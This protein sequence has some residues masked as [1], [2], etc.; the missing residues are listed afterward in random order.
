M[1]EG[2]S[3]FGAQLRALRR[4]AGLSQEELAERSGLNVRTIRNLE[5]GLGR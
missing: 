1:D 5:C 2:G 4:V 3:Q